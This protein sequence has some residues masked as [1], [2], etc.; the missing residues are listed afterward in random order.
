MSLTDDWTMQILLDY[1]ESER[2]EGA[3]LFGPDLSKWPSKIFDA[4][5]LFKYEHNVIENAKFE[6]ER[7]IREAEMRLKR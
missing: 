3:S 2:F 1:A 5:A 7:S 6:M 4:F